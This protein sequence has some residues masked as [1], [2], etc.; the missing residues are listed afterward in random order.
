[1]CQL[2]D[3]LSPTYSHTF[4][5]AATTPQYRDELSEPVRGAVPLEE[6]PNDAHNRRTLRRYD[7]PQNREDT[8]ALK[9]LAA[10][11]HQPRVEIVRIVFCTAGKRA[12]EIAYLELRSTELPEGDSVAN[13]YACIDIPLA[14][15]FESP[16][17]N[18]TALLKRRLISLTAI[19]QSVEPP[20]RTTLTAN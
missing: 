6:N 4:P 15:L 20:S 8:A 16:V 11:D 5:K 2:A 9:L 1:M 18:L 17:E 3:A 7:T 12:E 13:L 10:V 14:T 19:T